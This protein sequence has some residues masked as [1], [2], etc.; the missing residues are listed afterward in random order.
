M[1]RT[2]ILGAAS[3]AALVAGSLAVSSGIGSSHREAPNILGG[4]DGR[5]HRR[6]RVHGAG[7]AGQR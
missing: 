4:P 6:L 5:Q 3:A 7:R 2:A 1:R